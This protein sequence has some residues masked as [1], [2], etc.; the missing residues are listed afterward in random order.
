METLIQNKI[1]PA[2]KFRD[3][4]F[5]LSMT[6]QCHLLL[7]L[8][9]HAFRLAVVEDASRAC[10][11]LEEYR[12]PTPPNET[13]ALEDLQ[14]IVKGH[15][16]LGAGSWK[17]VMATV[18]NQ[19][20]TLIPM[21]LFR[22][23]YAPRYL[24]LA[25]GSQVSAQEEVHYHVHPKLG[26]V[27]VFSVERSVVDWLLDLYPF[28]EVKLIHQTSA[29]IEETIMSP[30]AHLYVEKE[31]FTLVV[32][33]NGQLR[34]CNRFQGKNPTDLVYFVLFALNELGLEP[35]ETPLR[36]YGEVEWDDEMAI[37]LG[38]YVP[39]MSFGTD[40]QEAFNTQTP[41]HRYASLFGILLAI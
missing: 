5:G 25:R 12:W 3:E 1:L 23:E 21:A 6:N 30:Q 26:I 2:V 29:L 9:P 39:N 41:S 38:K 35:T 34:Y 4:R 22:R 31:A 27:S 13:K 16:F 11:W 15:E 10:L 17:S 14:S 18:M 19:S 37:D 32:G 33:H 7:E 28:Q 36:L 8:K 24:Y 40:Y 20:F